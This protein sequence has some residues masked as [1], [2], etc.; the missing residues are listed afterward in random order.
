MNGLS[1]RSRTNPHRL[2]ATASAE[3]MARSTKQ[4]GINA[5][6]ESLAV[7][8]SD[9]IAH[10]GCGIGCAPLRQSGGDDRKAA[11]VERADR[12]DQSE[13]KNAPQIITIYWGIG[14]SLTVPASG[15][16]MTST[17]AFSVSNHRL[18]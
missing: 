5:W 13:D 9:D 3:G 14:S 11:A 8:R 7:L 2:G 15:F 17:A 18:P 1:F 10:P 6:A 16:G 4:N 12:R